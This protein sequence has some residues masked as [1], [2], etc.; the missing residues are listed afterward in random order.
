MTFGSY[1]ELVRED[2]DLIYIATPNHCHYGN[3][4][5]AIRAGHNVLVKKP[6]PKVGENTDI[7]NSFSLILLR[8][9]VVARENKDCTK[10]G[11]PSNQA[12]RQL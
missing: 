2:L 10:L 5:L 1:E 7:W 8:L 11:Q 4:L 6:F 3:A 9:R 12:Q